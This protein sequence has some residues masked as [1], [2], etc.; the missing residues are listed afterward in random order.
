MKKRI[1][2]KLIV[3]MVSAILV[4]LTSCHKTDTPA[5]TG[6]LKMHLHTNIDSFEVDSLGEFYADANTRPIALKKAQFYISNIQ[7]LSSSGAWK[8]VPGAFVL[9]RYEEEDYTLANVPA[10]NYTDVRFD[11][12]LDSTT[13]ATWPTLHSAGGADSSLTHTDMYFGSAT[14]GYIFMYLTG[15]VD[16]SPAHDGSNIQSFS[17]KIG[18]ASNH[19]TV[20]LT[21]ENFT[22][23]PGL[24]HFVHLIADYGKLLQGIDMTNA[25]N[26]NCDATTNP[27]TANT[28]SNNFDKLIRY[29]M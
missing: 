6:T 27:T 15:N 2:T 1:D 3:L 11:I 21:T 9:K 12:G 5:Q 17:Y 22:V 4:V 19:K 8:S 7:V 18:G 10:G 16:I 28:I 13:N 29:E 26:R 23:Y 24:D 20:T 25:A 14:Q